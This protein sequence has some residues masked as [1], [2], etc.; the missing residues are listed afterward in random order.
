MAP[1]T[2]RGE[3]ASVTAGDTWE[4]I[5]DFKDYTPTDGSGT[6]TLSYAIVGPDKLI[7]DASWSVAG[8]GDWTITIPA[9]STANLTTGTY[10]WTAILTGGSGFS[11]ERATPDS[12]VFH[13]Q[14]NPALLAAGDTLSSAA[15]NLVVVE[16]AIAG[17]LTA[18]MQSYSIGGR[19][20]TAIPMNE[21]MALRTRFREE[22][23]RERNPGKVGPVRL[24]AFGR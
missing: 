3:P 24:V 19:S 1:T 23:W 20:V 15:K 13:V 21:L 4:W 2:P 12:G 9:A 7:W 16:A 10:R 18:D 6:W 5:K 17:R 8:T 11:G 14:P 22:L